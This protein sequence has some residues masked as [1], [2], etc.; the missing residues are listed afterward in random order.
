MTPSGVILNECEPV[1]ENLSR[2]NKNTTKKR[3][4]ERYLRCIEPY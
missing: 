4:P 2:K 1:A 3:C